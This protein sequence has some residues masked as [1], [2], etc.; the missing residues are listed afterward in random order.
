[1]TKERATCWIIGVLIMAG[2]F[3][4][5]DYGLKGPAGYANYFFDN[6]TSDDVYLQY[7]VAEDL[8]GDTHL[9]GVLFPDSTVRFHSHKLTEENPTPGISFQWIRVYKVYGDTTD[10]MVL[11]MMPVSDSLWHMEYVTD[12][13]IGERDWTFVLEKIP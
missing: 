12:F 8:G 3:V 5:C 7:K 4:S 2:F 10:Q 11:E 13:D 1:M 9:T 6:S